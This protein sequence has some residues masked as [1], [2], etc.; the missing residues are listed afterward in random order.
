MHWQ[1]DQPELAQA[2]TDHQAL[3]SSEVLATEFAEFTGAAADSALGSPFSDPALGLTFR[4][5]LATGG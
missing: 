5:R 2:L 3:V 1:A 4:L